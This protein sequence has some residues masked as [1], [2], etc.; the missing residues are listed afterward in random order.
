MY[1]QRAGSTHGRGDPAYRTAAGRTLYGICRQWSAI[2][3]RRNKVAGVFT[4]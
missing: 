3:D 4:G 1:E 2:P